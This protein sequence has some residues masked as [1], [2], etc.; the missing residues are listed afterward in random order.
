MS[1][2]AAYAEYRFGPTEQPLFPGSP[3]SP[4]HHPW[5]KVAYIAVALLVGL[6]AALGNALVTVNLTNIAGS[7]GVTVAQATWLSSMYVAFNASANLLLVRARMQYGIPRVTHALLIAYAATTVLQ[8]AAPSFGTALLVRAASGTVATGLTTMTIY[9]LLQIFPPK[10]RPMALL[11]GIS[12][13]QF[14]VPLARMF[15]VTLLVVGQWQGLHLFELG[16]TLAVSAAL[17]A[18][19]LLPSICGKAFEP[20]DFLTFALVLPGMILLCGALGAGRYVWWTDTAWVGIALAV[21]TMLLATAFAIEHNRARPLLQMSWITSRDIARLAI[22]ALLVRFALAEQTYGAVGL[23]TAG[24][25]NNDQL[26]LLFA[27]VMVA[28]ILGTATAALTLSIG[29]IPW[30]VMA[31]AVIIGIGALIDTS[32]TNLTRPAQLYLSQSLLGFGTC[33]FIGPALLFGFIRVI[34]LGPNYLVS[35]L[36]VFSASQNIGGLL[37]SALLGTYQVMRTRAHAGALSEHLLAS[38]PQVM[39]RLTQQG[40]AGLYAALQREA[41]VLAFNDV[42]G[43]VAALSFAIALYL[44]FRIMRLRYLQRQ[45]STQ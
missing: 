16:L 13:T 24:G 26:H 33:L 19:P 27:C 28:M 25:L 21:A 35:F 20:L 36:V 30:Q 8:L 23:L 41:A 38:D 3:Y 42:F 10:K 44:I 34:Q 18:V 39:A 14:S 1:A 7:L 2:T 29:G 32:S 37:G 12:I 45:G 15:P 5:R 11:L 17:W 31:A 9:N 4:A 6:S 40:G 22:I 43:A